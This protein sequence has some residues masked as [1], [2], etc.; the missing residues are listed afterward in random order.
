MI[1][2]PPGTKVFLACRPID[3][4]AGF[5]GLAAKV[6]QIIGA[7]P[8]SAM[9]GGSNIEIRLRTNSDY[10]TFSLEAIEQKPQP[11]PWRR[12]RKLRAFLSYLFRF[13]W[14]IRTAWR[15]SQIETAGKQIFQAGALLSD[16]VA[17]LT[18]QFKPDQDAELP[19]NVGAA[20]L[21]E[22]TMGN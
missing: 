9:L 20:W 18:I 5:E 3:L 4:C 14:H 16:N 1:A 11:M 13:G 22:L 2:L 8:F 21:N 15:I 12:G 10:S 7:D 19:G 17:N 6:R